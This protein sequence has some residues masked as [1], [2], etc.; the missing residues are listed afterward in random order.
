MVQL[1]MAGATSQRGPYSVDQKLASGLGPVCAERNTFGWS[2]L[3]GAARGNSGGRA[4]PAGRLL[5]VGE[6]PVVIADIAKSGA[7][8][9]IRTPDVLLR[10]Q[11]LYPAELRARRRNPFQCT[12]LATFSA[13][14]TERPV[15]TVPSFRT[16]LG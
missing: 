16:L 7:P 5:E 11:M 10:R 2:V 1:R 13:R 14:I 12:S 9:E 8:G 6:M 15:L 4:Y 3:F